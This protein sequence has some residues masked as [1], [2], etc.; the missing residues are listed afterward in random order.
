[1]L[2]PFALLLLPRKWFC[3]FSQTETAVVNP[4]FGVYIIFIYYVHP[5]HAHR[6]R[7]RGREKAGGREREGGR[8]REGERG[9]KRGGGGEYKRAARK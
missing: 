8:G 4:K 3:S 5:E 6:E 9:G 2:R 1:M 7:G